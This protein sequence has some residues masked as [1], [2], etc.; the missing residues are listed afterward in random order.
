LR[1]VAR[2]FQAFTVVC[3]ALTGA[4][5]ASAGVLDQSQPAADAGIFVFVPQSVG[6]T[7]TAGIS[8]ALDQ[9]DVN[10]AIMRG[11]PGPLTV[12]V[13]NAT[14]A[15]P[16]KYVLAST[17]IPSSG[18]STAPNESWTSATFD[19]PA[20]VRQGGRYAIA[21]TVGGGQ[22]D[23]SQTYPQW[24]VA[25]AAEDVVPGS[26]FDTWDRLDVP[27]WTEI[28][29]SDLSFKTYVVP[30]ATDD[31]QPALNVTHSTDGTNGWNTSNRV[32]LLVS[33]SDDDSGLPGAPTCTDNGAPLAVD[34]VASPYAATVSG[35]DVHTIVCEVNDRA[36]NTRTATDEVKI[37]T[38][39][40]R[41]V[42]VPADGSYVYLDW[43]YAPVCDARDDGSG[44]AARGSV[45][46]G[47]TTPPA[48][49]GDFTFTCDGA[50]D[51]AGNTA[52]PATIGFHVFYP[53][54][55]GFLTPVEN[56]DSYGNFI[57]NEA[58]A[59]ATIPIKFSLGGRDRGMNI[60]AA[61][62]P[63]SLVVACD[64]T[65]PTDVIDQYVTTSVTGLTYE[66]GSARYTYNWKTSNDWGGSCRQFLLKL[67]DG[68]T[69][70]VR[71][72]FVK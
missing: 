52:A 54:P 40:P 41:V 51:V 72:K 30:G 68:S 8:G 2:L 26:L 34:G 37:D 39:P 21:L 63:S 38:V 70:E 47:L 35:E 45:T 5:P 50:T 10:T 12:Q 69:H 65:L 71:F 58:K 13:R 55:D 9:V 43:P 28:A 48:D 15:G 31:V 46:S 3:A 11:D 14:D 18:Q 36:G 66:P 24:V 59:G 4:A 6:Q 49:V 53:W 7:F 23:S 25:R 44:V 29:G 19:S 1:K 57:Q 32:S 62:S 27:S 61:N 20:N 60:L 67:R 56:L 42:A 16:G 33:A 17:T 22:W 64:S